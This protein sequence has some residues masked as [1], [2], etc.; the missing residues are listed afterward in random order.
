MTEDSA[1]DLV[2]TNL[3]QYIQSLNEK[4]SPE[5]KI[6]LMLT[7]MQAQLSHGDINNLSRFWKMREF[8]LEQFKQTLSPVKRFHL[9]KDYRKTMDEIIKLKAVLD[10]KQSYNKEQIEE[11]IRSTV[12][13][14]KNLDSQI[15]KTLDIEIPSNIEF[16]AKN[17][18]EYQDF[19]KEVS[20]YNGYTSRINS[21][22]KEL[23]NLDISFKDKKPLLTQI[24]VL[25]D[26]VF[27]K[28]RE[29][30]TQISVLYKN[31]I[32]SYLKSIFDKS[33]LK[34]PYFT[35]KEQIKSLQNFSKVI[36][37]NVTSFSEIRETLSQAWDKIKVLEQEKRTQKEAFKKSCTENETKILELIKELSEKKSK[38]PRKDFDR[39]VNQI[40]TSIKRAELFK[41]VKNKLTD[42][43]ED[44]LDELLPKAKVKQE[45]NTQAK[46]EEYFLL[47]KDKV[48]YWDYF[49][50]ASE[51]KRLKDLIDNSS[52]M[53][54]KLTAF[55]RELFSIK[56]KLLQKLIE[57]IQEGIETEEINQELKSF[58]QSVV[59]DMESFKKKLNSSNQSIE[60]A[61]LYNELLMRSKKHLKQLEKE[62]QTT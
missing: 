4:S 33:D 31:D 56:E 14:L 47:I 49:A 9:W 28:R 20:L 57:E 16:L 60:K 52:V 15:E 37:L 6:A 38:L 30:L 50:L 45:D 5:E 26:Q 62:R 21:L 1:I 35:Y 25:S 27:P 53:E 41:S 10:E 24:Y 2:K 3:D 39:E 12:D 17:A 40:E 58:K 46:I 7:Y 59:A 22:K 51:Y 34:E 23:L 54:S 18:K 8:C 61:M 32:N 44:T 55:E 43:L 42:S 19:Q 11:A 48:N 36:S 13:G 29:L